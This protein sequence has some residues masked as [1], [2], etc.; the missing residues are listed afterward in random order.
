MSLPVPINGLN[1]IG[2]CAAPAQVD[3]YTAGQVDRDA[4]GP[5]ALWKSWGAIV[6]ATANTKN[7]RLK[8]SRATR[9][10]AATGL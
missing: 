1:A 2:G 3:G 8:Q 10:L 6:N 4:R 7:Q 5:L 9:V